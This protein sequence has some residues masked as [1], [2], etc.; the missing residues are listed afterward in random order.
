MYR[1]ILFSLLTIALL[2]L[3]IGSAAA[4]SIERNLFE[5]I[6]ETHFD[7]T[8]LTARHETLLANGTYTWRHAE[9]PHFVLHF[10]RGIFARKVARLAEFYYTYISK[11]LGALDD[12]REGRSHIFI[13][14]DTKKWSGFLSTWPTAPPW[15][16]AFVQE[17]ALFLPHQKTRESLDVL[18]H[19]MTHLVIHRFFEHVPPRWLNEGLAEWYAAFAYPA[20]KGVKK[21]QR[22]VF[23]KR[24]APLYDLNR[25]TQLKTYP[26][27]VASFYETSKLLIGYL[28]LEYGDE[29]FID[30]CSSILNGASTMAALRQHYEIDD[31]YAIDEPF[32]AFS[33]Y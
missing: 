11:D 14:R 9:T 31:I 2:S 4:T 30:F 10:E 28:R 7:H 5:E 32:R 16:G 12:I 33:R 23:K 1:N 22:A 26:A 29:P 6:G 25:L 8:R 19:E 13:F 15:A 21:S 24:S 17:G 3:P 18:A 27:D 20:F